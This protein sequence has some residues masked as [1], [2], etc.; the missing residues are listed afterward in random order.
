MKKHLFSFVLLATTGLTLYS[1]AKDVSVIDDEEQTESTGR[2]VVRA[3]AAGANSGSTDEQEKAE[4]SYPVNLYVFDS[5]EKC[6]AV[7][8]LENES[9]DISISL[10]AGKYHVYAIAG[11]KSADYTIPSKSEAIP[12]SVIKLKDGHA[13]SDLMTGDN[14]VTMAENE[15]NTLNMTLERKV[16]NVQSIVMENIPQ[17]VKS[18]SVE[19]S[20]LYSDL[21]INGKFNGTDG[22]ETVSLTKDD[23]AE[24]STWKSSKPT[25]M[26][27]A[28]GHA[29]VKVSMV[30]SNGDKDAFS[31][32][33]D[34]V[35]EANYKVNIKGS[36]KNEGLKLTGVITGATWAGTRSIEFTGG[37]TDEGQKVDGDAPAAGTAYKGCY[38]VKAEKAESG[39]KTTVL[40]MSPTYNDEWT[41]KKGDTKAMQTEVESAIKKLAISGIEGWRLPTS[42]EIKYVYNNRD[43][44]NENID[45]L[46]DIKRLYN[47]SY[48]YQQGDD[49][50]ALILNTGK[51]YAPEEI[52]SGTS[53]TLRV[54]ATLTFTKEE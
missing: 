11:A 47:G 2:L 38:V 15:K 6:A 12:E 52:S 19:L 20:P 9:D 10:Q 34:D 7:E 50:Y 26:F 30:K 32:S 37:A 49:I 45:K 54:F 21:M 48:L 5:A 25:Y 53:T 17:D 23:T 40:L 18:V 29:T 39:N 8:T 33:C 35:L 27:A 16:M 28:S 43:G 31:Y 51:T 46:N 44:I 36:Y 4:V 13:Q 3:T 41:F 1:C 24:S 22:S 42:D 14:A